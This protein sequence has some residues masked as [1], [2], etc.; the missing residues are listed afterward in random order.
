[1]SSDIA[2]LF[3][4]KSR[5]LL[6]DP[7]HKTLV[8]IKKH[9]EVA[10]NFRLIILKDI[11]PLYSGLSE[12]LVRVVKRAD[13]IASSF[14]RWLLNVLY[15]G[16]RVSD[17]YFHFN[18]LLNIL[19]PCYKSSAITYSGDIENDALD[20]AK[21]IN[22]ILN[23]VSEAIDDRGERARI[24]YS[25]LHVLLEPYWISNGLPISLAD[26]R[27]PTHTVFDHV[28]ATA[29]VVNIALH[30]EPSGYLVKIDVPS[31]QKFIGSARKAGDFWAGSWILSNLTW[32]TLEPL[33]F[34]YGPDILVTPSPRLNPYLL[35]T[36][37]KIIEG[38]INGGNI[39]NNALSI[40]DDVCKTYVEALGSIEE[41][42][43]ELIDGIGGVSYC[44]KF[45]KAFTL[46][47]LI[48]ATAIVILPKL[49]LVSVNDVRNKVV[50]NYGKAWSDLL[51]DIEIKLSELSR[52]SKTY[53]V[54]YG[55]LKYFKN[56][57][58]SPPTGI[59]VDV[60]DLN[61]VYR[62]LKNCLM[63]LEE[64]CREVGLSK[65][66]VE[67]IKGLLKERGVSLDES[68]LAMKL[69][70]SVALI[71]VLRKVSTHTPIP[72]PRPFWVFNE[73]QNN[74]EATIN[75]EALSLSESSWRPC[76]LDG[77]EPAVLYLG[78]TLRGLFEDFND[79]AV[80]KLMKTLNI[81]V[82]RDIFKI[83]YLRPIIRPG[84][85]LGPYCL[86]KRLTYKAYSQDLRNI[87]R[88]ASTDDVA[89]LKLNAT[90]VNRDRELTDKIIDKVSSEL[91][92]MGI[93][94]DYKYVRDVI[95][96]YVFSEKTIIIDRD[97]SSAAQ[98][99]GLDYSR[100]VDIMSKSI[101][102]ACGE[103]KDLRVFINELLIE[104]K[105]Y[106]N[107]GKLINSADTAALSKLCNLRTSY[108]IIK[109]DADNMG[110]L[111]NGNLSVLGLDIHDYIDAIFNS[112]KDEAKVLHNGEEL[113]GR[114]REN[115][116][117]EFKDALN[118][119]GS[120]VSAL[121]R[122]RAGILISP[123]YS[124]IVSSALIVSA[125][126][127]VVLTLKHYGFPIYSGGDDLLALLPVETAFTYVFKS[128]ERFHG[129][130]MFY[131]AISKGLRI[132]IIPAIPTGRSYSMRYAQ[133]M[134]VMSIEISKAI[135][136]LEDK[137]KKSKWVGALTGSKDT[138]VISDSRSNVISLLPL[139][140]RSDRQI[141]LSQR[142]IAEVTAL[143]YL[144]TKTRLLSTSLPEDVDSRIASIIKG[145]VDAAL[146]VSLERAL[147]SIVKHCV[148]I[149]TRYEEVV[150]DVM[151]VISNSHFTRVKEVGVSNYLHL[152]L[153]ILN[154]LKVMRAYP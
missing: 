110:S 16:K 153:H 133:L 99:L 82:G 90:I 129:N 77:E 142:D 92:K 152:I 54:L 113:E 74:L 59:R 100:F 41:G 8:D 53:E 107:V 88:L 67:K 23:R 91:L 112:M 71:S 50:E 13:V 111:I 145:E 66:S 139:T 30:E 7:P 95:T 61:D 48:P 89:L 56:S 140:L 51:E 86:F 136:L 24:T 135:E 46:M 80:D 149:N 143:L 44:E 144:L 141:L 40:E 120:L 22:G 128:R 33:I 148:K 34:K 45:K 131:Y 31:V 79:D 127:D 94:L 14:D 36:T 102:E 2:R 75:Y 9:E 151:R 17:V 25:L 122:G 68:E 18:K 70:W 150:E 104:H 93:Q 118:A 32:K 114:E 55:L 76:S 123:A 43:K 60:V 69:L 19:N 106:V 3:I 115:V 125:L 57:L 42:L 96:N 35:L 28:Y 6:H 10:K 11:D 1:M 15:Y 84:E 117:E 63:G 137:A 20:V 5:A 81:D 109:A 121:T 58:N 65:D 116:L 26:T 37:L 64:K 105:D 132:P 78:K 73:A 52:E 146:L 38:R 87:I 4:V 126:R 119:V 21:R 27:A 154:T 72:L 147:D 49:D 83:Q 97:I 47:P 85:A 103:Y 134:D 39:K 98:L 130:G 29:A 12:E 62:D 124:Y 108:A 138:V 101:E